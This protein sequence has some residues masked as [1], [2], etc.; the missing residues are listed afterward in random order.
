MAQKYYAVRKGRQPGI[1]RTWPETQKQVS[2]Y[3]QAQYKSFTS[4]KDAQDFM[5]GKASPTR[6]AHSK[7][8]SN[9]ATG[10]RSHYCLY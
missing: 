4:E 2:G 8:V 3:P 6:P 5:A 7:S 10:Q 9:Q 1:Y